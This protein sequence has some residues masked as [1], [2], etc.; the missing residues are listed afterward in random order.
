MAATATVGPGLGPSEVSPFILLRYSLEWCT[1]APEMVGLI[2]LVTQDLLVRIVLA[3]T[4]TARTRLALASRIVLTHV[5]VWLLGAG[6]PL[7]TRAL[8][9]IN[10]KQ[11]IGKMKFHLFRSVSIAPINREKYYNYSTWRCYVL[12]LVLICNIF[13]SFYPLFV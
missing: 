5:T 6:F 3:T 12:T 7:T 11:L 1:E 9:A 13:L 8:I 2:T 10:T 4:H